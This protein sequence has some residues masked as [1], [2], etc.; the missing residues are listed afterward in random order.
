MKFTPNSLRYAF[1]IVELVDSDAEMENR[2]IGEASIFNTKTSSGRYIRNL[3]E[4]GTN[5]HDRCS[6]ANMAFY[7]DPLI[8]KVTPGFNTREMGMGDDY[9]LLPEVAAHIEHIKD[10]YIRGEEI[11]PVKVQLIDGEPFIRQGHCRLRAAKQAI[12]E[13]HSVE[14]FICL[15]FTGD[16]LHAE[17]QTLSGNKGLPLSPV[18]IGESYKRL[19][20]GLGGWSTER[21]AQH[22]GVSAVTVTN[23]IRLTTLPLE[24]KKYIHAD[25]VSYTTVLE[26]VDQLGTTE[27]IAFIKNE[28][29]SIMAS[30]KRAKASST[31]PVLRVKPSSFKE[32]RVP[33]KLATRAVEGL[34]HFCT[35]LC[36]QLIEIPEDQDEV[37]VKLDR[38]TI[39]MLLT[40]KEDISKTE[41][42]QLRRANKRAGNDDKNSP[43]NSDENS[44]AGAT[45]SDQK[46]LETGSPEYSG[47]NAVLNKVG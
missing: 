38:A 35:N 26:M 8:I 18:A 5:N 19:T 22:Q 30:H 12:A 29:A 7:I 17:L 37:T 14:N 11:D 40:L 20:T 31:P 3:R 23:Y 21:V 36:E 4:F 43:N 34:K 46:M 13:G 27:A 32:P 6:T 45:S 28:L 25:N 10:A 44:R 15:E 47:V 2:M 39:E 16:E 33:P 24:L 41:Q 9:Y 42:K 1:A